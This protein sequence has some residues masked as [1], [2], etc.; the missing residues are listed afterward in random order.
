MATPEQIPTSPRKV[1]SPVTAASTEKRALSS[2]K[3]LRDEV[4]SQVDEIQDHISVV[5]TVVSE[6][7]TAIG[8]LVSKRE[9]AHRAIEAEFEA[10]LQAVETAMSARKAALQ[11]Q[12][13]KYFEVLELQLQEKESLLGE[14][15]VHFQTVVQEGVEALNLDDAWFF[16][17]YPDIK[18]DCGDSVVDSTR[19]LLAGGG[20]QWSVDFDQSLPENTKFDEQVVPGLATHGRVEEGSLGEEPTPAPAKAAESTAA[21]GGDPREEIQAQIKH[22]LLE[23]QVGRLSDA[24]CKTQLAELQ[25][26][27]NNLP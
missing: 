6:V 21:P 17:A 7:G 5:D 12:A 8:R 25:A 20:L 4:Q 24:A 26:K 10:Q 15:K 9:K 1:L 16:Q 22:L 13:T 18:L 14:E 2:A 11:D 3:P 27:L 23:M 19:A